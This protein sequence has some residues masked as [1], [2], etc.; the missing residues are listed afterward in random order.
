MLFNLN[1]RAGAQLVKHH[2]MISLGLLLAAV[3]SFRLANALLA[4]ASGLGTLELYLLG[5]LAIA[6]ALVYF[7]LKERRLARAEASDQV[8]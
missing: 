1:F 5:G 3:F 6:G 2:I 8:G 7:G 4:S